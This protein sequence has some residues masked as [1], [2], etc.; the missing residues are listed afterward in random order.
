MCFGSLYVRLF[1]TVYLGFWIPPCGF[2]NRFLREELEFWVII[3]SR[4]SDSLSLIIQD[5]IIRNTLHVV[6]Q[7]FERALC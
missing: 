3:V 7:G 4:I 1:K 5:S 2:R 6:I